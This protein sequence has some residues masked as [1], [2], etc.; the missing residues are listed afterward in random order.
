MNYIQEIFHYIDTEKV[1]WYFHSYDKRNHKRYKEKIKN[2]G[3]L[4]SFSEFG[5]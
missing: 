1:T 2:C 3:F 4:G 5:E